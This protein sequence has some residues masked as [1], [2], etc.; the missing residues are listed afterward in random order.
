MTPC[1]IVTLTKEQR[2]EFR[3][4]RDA[5]EAATKAYVSFKTNFKQRNQPSTRSYAPFEEVEMEILDQPE[6]ADGGTTH[7]YFLKRLE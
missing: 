1:K 2:D 6:G 5:S 4:L 3:K 7:A